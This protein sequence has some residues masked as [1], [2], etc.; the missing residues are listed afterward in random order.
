[1]VLRLTKENLEYLG[2][3]ARLSDYRENTG[4]KTHYHDHKT[5]EPESKKNNFL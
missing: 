2:V 1:M 3:I 4:N 5:L